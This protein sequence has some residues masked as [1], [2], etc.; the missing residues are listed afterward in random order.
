MWTWQD[1][2]E[3]P[4]LPFDS[5]PYPTRTIR[6]RVRTYVRSV[7]HVTTKR[8][9]VDHNLWVWGSVPRALRARGSPAI[10]FCKNC[11]LSIIIIIIIFLIIIINKT[12]FID[13]KNRLFT[14][15]RIWNIKIYT[16]CTFFL[17]TKENC[18]KMAIQRLLIT[19]IKSIKKLIKKIKNYLK[20]IIQTDKNRSV[21]K[22]IWVHATMHIYRAI[23]LWRLQ[24][25]FVTVNSEI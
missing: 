5:L 15:S 4:S 8:K 17:C 9:E 3:T 20:I 13:L 25:S 10:N 2:P 1:T 24:E 14:D 11:F 6:R 21:S 22:N 7:S 16:L 23:I 19:I 18:R 12:L